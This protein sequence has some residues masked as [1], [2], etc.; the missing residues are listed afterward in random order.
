[1]ADDEFD[2]Y[3]CLS[4]KV[5]ECDDELRAMYGKPEG[6]EQEEL[7]QALRHTSANILALFESGQIPDKLAEDLTGY[8]PWERLGNRVGELLGYNYV[9]EQGQIAVAAEVVGRLDG[10]PGRIRA[11]LLAFHLLQ[12]SNPTATALKYLRQVSR[13][14]L[15]GFRPEVFIMCGAA[16]EAA[17]AD[18]FPDSYLLSKGLR[19]KYA[20]T[21]VFSIGQRM[22]IEVQEPVLTDSDRKRF[23]Q[24]VNW[25]N[26]VAH[27]QPDIVPDASLVLVETAYLLGKIH[28]ASPVDAG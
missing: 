18:R 26:D 19:P 22:K 1:M 12:R 25:R 20:I 24:V 14:Y 9:L 23:W 6:K 11:S 17:I 28:P 7:H 2:L 27:V 3:L 8:K 13:L 5:D 16:L 15:A 4:G 21:G 10:V